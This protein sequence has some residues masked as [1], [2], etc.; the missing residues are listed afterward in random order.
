LKL[1]QN[2]KL[3]FRYALFCISLGIFIAFTINSTLTFANTADKVLNKIGFKAVKEPTQS[4]SKLDITKLPQKDVKFSHVDFEDLKQKVSFKIK[5]PNLEILE[6]VN[7]EYLEDLDNSNQP[8]QVVKMEY[9]F[10]NQPIIIIQGTNRNYLGIENGEVLVPESI[11]NK[12]FPVLI[13]GQ[14]GFITSSE[15]NDI[16]SL[17]LNE[18]GI[19]ISI[20]AENVSKE[21]IITIAETMN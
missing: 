8:T 12:S 10:N 2:F 6:F 19:G 3:Y 11:L 14:K 17:Y 15:G 4:S 1:N 16:H 9:K 5:Q 21:D 18:N 13:N 7:L 20:W